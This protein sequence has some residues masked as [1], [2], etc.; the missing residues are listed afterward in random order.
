MHSEIF[1]GKEFNWRSFR[2]TFNF[3][4]FSFFSALIK[5]SSELEAKIEDFKAKHFSSSQIIGLHIRY[6]AYNFLTV[7]YFHLILIHCPRT[8]GAT[9][10]IS[11]QKVNLFS[12]CASKLSL[13]E[14]VTWFLATDSDEVT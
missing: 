6:P 2:V 8:K 1:F 5:P 9:P 7:I 14:N 13:T 12:F 10:G 4:Y 3:D 11:P